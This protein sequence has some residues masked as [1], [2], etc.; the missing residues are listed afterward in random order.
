MCK[1]KNVLKSG[2]THTYAPPPLTVK[3][4]MKKRDLKLDSQL[5]EIDKSKE[6]QIA[7][8]G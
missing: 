1:K 5:T 8:G 6:G 2:V 4:Y 3:T 7:G